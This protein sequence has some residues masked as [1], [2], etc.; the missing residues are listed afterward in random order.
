M[1]SEEKEAKTKSGGKRCR[2]SWCMYMYSFMYVYILEPQS[3][4]H[5]DTCISLYAHKAFH[6]KVRLNDLFHQ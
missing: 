3:T 1:N 5:V 4:A 2:D 6:W